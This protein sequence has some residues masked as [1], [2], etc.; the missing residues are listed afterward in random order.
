MRPYMD[1]VMPGAWKAAETFAY[2]VRDEAM[3]AGLTIQE[4]ELIK[5]R[6]SQINECAFCLDLHAREARKSGLP[7]Q[8]L[9][10][11]AA[12]RETDL[13]D[14][15]EKAVIAVAEAS[16][17]FP[18]TEELEADLFGARTV[19]GEEAFVAAEWIAVTINAFNRISVLSR[20]PV[21]PRDDD[22]TV[23]R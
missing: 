4:S 12:W 10:V 14:E 19:L 21:R 8:K 20:H 13:F 22:G 16:T 17:L 3:R 11:L 6:A 15:R 23:L 5:L 9:D 2:A 7:Q 18:L 1:K